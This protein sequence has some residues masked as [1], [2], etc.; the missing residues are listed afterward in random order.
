MQVGGF[1]VSTVRVRPIGWCAVAE[2]RAVGGDHDERAPRGRRLGKRG[3]R[4]RCRADRLDGERVR[5]VGEAGD[6]AVVAERDDVV[7]DR[8]QCGDRSGGIADRRPRPRLARQRVAAPDASAVDVEHDGGVVE[9]GGDQAG[10]LRLEA[11]SHVVE[12]HDRREV[13]ARQLPDAQRAGLPDD[14]AGVG[15]QHLHADRQ[16]HRVDDLVG[17]RV[18]QLQFV[19]VGVVDDHGVRR[20]LDVERGAGVGDPDETRHL[21]RGTVHLPDDPVGPA[22]EPGAAV[23]RLGADRGSAISM[24]RGDDHGREGGDDEA[25]D[26]HFT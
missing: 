22:D 5:T 2:H 21:A 13:V 18:D 23:V 20:L 10:P 11:R 16:R 4:D 6:G 17:A 24:D 3:D 19:G 15:R 1:A 8:A 7:A 9:G 14:G 12:R 25:D 26:D